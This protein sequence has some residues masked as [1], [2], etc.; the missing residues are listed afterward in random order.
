MYNDV[1]RAI[2]A[3]RPDALIGGHYAT[4]GAGTAAG[5]ADPSSLQGGFGVV[6]Q[7]ALDVLTYWLQNKVGAQF[8]S[9]AG[10]PAA[11]AENP[12]ASDQY[13]AAVDDWV[14]GLNSQTYPGSSTLP[15]MWAE[16]Y[17]GLAST[18][19]VARGNKAVAVDVS[20]AIEAGVTGANYLLLWEMEGAA[21][22]ASPTTGVGV[23]TDTTGAQGGA[24]TDLYV[25]LSDL[26]RYFPPGAP[27]YFAFDSGPICA[28]VTSHAVMLVSQ[29][30]RPMTASVDQ[31]PVHLSPYQVDVVPAN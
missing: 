27:L 2:K 21:G 20:S 9:L 13:F 31:T 7:R 12:F 16:F 23:W 4:V 18:T 24:P 11:T 6:D 15:I 8:L 30:S 1:Y 29:S 14:R 26:H 3:V 5:T 19:G 28:L 17:P 22:G 10:G 25:A